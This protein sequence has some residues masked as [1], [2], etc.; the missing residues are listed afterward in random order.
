MATDRKVKATVKSD[1]GFYVGDVCYQMSDEDYFGNWSED[2]NNFEG[3]HE[4]RG[5]KFAVAETAYGD[6]E[7]VDNECHRY[8]VDA[9]DIGILPLDL[10]QSKDVTELNRDGR[11]VD[12][13]QAE[14]TAHGG[15]IDISFDNGIRIH[16]DTRDAENEQEEYDE[17]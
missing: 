5:H 6:G 14:C 9:G 15:V 1:N 16:I 3:E 7:Y 11:Y 8:G 4:I 13:N 12:A 17:E 10:C 2:F